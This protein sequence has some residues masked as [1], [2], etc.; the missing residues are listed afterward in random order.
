MTRAWVAVCMLA[1]AACSH[2]IYNK[3]ILAPDS[4]EAARKALPQDLLECRAYAEKDW[5]HLPN[6][7]EA[8][9][10]WNLYRLCLEDRGYRIVG[11]TGALFDPLPPKD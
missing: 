8:E 7:G 4:T 1:T 2:P 11:W 10:R 6:I 5:E 3:P 9:A